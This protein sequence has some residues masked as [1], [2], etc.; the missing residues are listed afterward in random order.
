MRKSRMAI[1]I[2]TAPIG[3]GP[4]E[5]QAHHLWVLNPMYMSF[6]FQKQELASACYQPCHSLMVSGL[7][8]NIG[9]ARN[10]KEDICMG[11]LLATPFSASALPCAV[12]M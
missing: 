4:K 11:M 10:L 8:V 5:M 3:Q 1:G 9:R 12:S 7:E 2:R 6:I